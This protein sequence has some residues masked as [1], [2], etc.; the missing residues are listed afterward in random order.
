MSNSHPNKVLCPTHIL[1]N[2]MVGLGHLDETSQEV[3]DWISTRQ[4]NTML[5]TQQNYKIKIFS[6]RDTFLWFPKGRKEHNQKIQK[7][8][9]WPVENTIFTAQQY[10]TTCQ[11]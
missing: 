7:T 6:M 9:V 10:Y 1:T 3:V 8:M 5:W 11:H 2:H 4:C